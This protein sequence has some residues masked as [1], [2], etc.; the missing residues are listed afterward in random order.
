MDPFC[1]PLLFYSHPATSATNCHKPERDSC[2]AG[3]HRKTPGGKQAHRLHQPPADDD[4]LPS[5]QGLVHRF[6]F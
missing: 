6:A 3:L 1:N 5:I 2:P 4:K